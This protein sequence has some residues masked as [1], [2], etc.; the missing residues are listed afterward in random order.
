MG[1]PAGVQVM[2]VQQQRVSRTHEFLE[3]ALVA[4]AAQSRGCRPGEIAQDP[5]IPGALPVRLEGNL[6]DF[7]ARKYFGAA[8]PPLYAEPGLR[9]AQSDAIACNRRSALCLVT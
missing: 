2:Q 6:G 8:E 7:Q 5:L 1:Q 4:A 9:Q 3:R